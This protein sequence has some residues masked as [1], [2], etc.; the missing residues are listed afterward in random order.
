MGVS[1][2]VL[3]MNI[4]GSFPLGFTGLISLQSKGLS[5]VFSNTTAQKHQFFGAQLSLY[6]NDFFKY[7][8]LKKKKFSLKPALSLS[9]FT[10][11][12]RLF[13]FPSRSP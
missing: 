3:Q 7:F 12:K 6:L 2:S 11:I 5:R 8:S 13:S 9:S 10:L 1:A 4:Q